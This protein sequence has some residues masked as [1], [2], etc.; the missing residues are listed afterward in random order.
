MSGRCGAVTAIQ[1]FGGALN[2]NVHFH[3]IVL[4]GLHVEGPCGVL[5][6]RLEVF[7]GVTPNARG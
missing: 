1:R 7:G 2:L 6:F 4:D 5:T 3:S